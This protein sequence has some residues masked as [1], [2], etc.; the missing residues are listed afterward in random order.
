VVSAPLT[1]DANAP[2][3][4]DA[5][6]RLRDE[7]IPNAFDGTATEVYVGG[8]TATNLDF[9]N[10]LDEF[11]PIVFAFVLGLSFLLLMV[12]F[13]SIVVPVTAIVMN[14][15]SVGAAYGLVVLVFQKGVGN[16]LFGFQ[17]TPTIEA[18][19]P[20]FLF[21]ILFGLSMDYH[22]FLLSRVRE[23]YDKTRRNSE[24]VAEGLQSTARIITGAAIIMVAVFGGFATGRMVSMQQIGFGLAVAVLLDATIVRTIL[25][26]A[27]MALLGDR[28]WY[29]PRWLQWLPNLS[30]EGT[31][32]PVPTTALAAITAAQPE[33]TTL[34][35]EDEEELAA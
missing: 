9:N 10:T 11:T 6:E 4:Y 20:I 29:F 3:S 16:E 2:E 14:L 34:L 15:L 18:W 12:A 31:T 35:T 13:R 30:I 26:P 27:T 23:H 1:T 19:L 7:V 22:V 5:I 28:N 21:C 25:V 17:Q 24:S 33:P 32:V 8:E